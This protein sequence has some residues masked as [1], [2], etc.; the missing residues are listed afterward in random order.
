[1]QDLTADERKAINSLQRLAD[2]W[3]DSLWLFSASGSLCVM[4]K[5]K[6]GEHVLTGDGPGGGVDPDYLVDTIEGISN[7]GGDW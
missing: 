3:P 5:G 7:D 6:D 2:R 4:R 1:M